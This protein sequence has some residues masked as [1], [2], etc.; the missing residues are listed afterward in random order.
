MGQFLNLPQY[1]IVYYH[2]QG[3]FHSLWR[4]LNKQCFKTL[5][6]FKTRSLGFQPNSNKIQI[7]TCNFY[8]LEFP[9]YMNSTTV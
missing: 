1:S 5:W 7:M 9:T 6:Y 2:S 8:F 4:S 3:P